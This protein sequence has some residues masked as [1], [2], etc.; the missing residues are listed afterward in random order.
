MDRLLHNFGS[1]VLL[2]TL[3]L[4]SQ[5]K[6]SLAYEPP[7]I[8]GSIKIGF[9]L[10]LS[11]DWAFLG[12]DVRDA[13][14]LAKQDLDN[15]SFHVELKFED[16]HGEL[17]ESAAAAYRLINLEKVDAI[18]SVISGVGLLIHPIAERAQVLNFGL[19]SNTNVAGGEFNF[20]NYI[21]TDEGA[22][23]FLQ[24]LTSGKQGRSRLGI[25]SL[26][27]EGFNQI[28]QQVKAQSA[29]KPVDILFVESF[30]PKTADFRPLILRAFRRT[31][32]TLLI[33]G[34]SPEIETL[35]HQLH[36]LNK[37]AELTSIEAF[38]LAQQKQVFD[39]SWYIDPAAPSDE[40]EERFRKNYGHEYTPPAPFAYDTVAII[41]KGFK[42]AWQGDVR[43]SRVSVA[44]T[45]HGIKEFQGIVGKLSVDS[46]G[47]FHSSPS[48]KEMTAGR[49]V[50]LRH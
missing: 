14:L 30:E 13:V 50:A 20:T 38:G 25:F 24:R 28:A 36:E 27:E 49:G 23:A 8:T 33:L 2:A 31:P 40:F 21:T 22:R 26:N 4:T 48:I 29:D 5:G 9:V 34:L 44:R 41:V 3:F 32:Q 10:P 47:I 17:K 6:I 35:A 43:P 39:G 1:F 16:N 12:N 42:E 19:C 45:I 7:Q 46:Q 18:V 11:G 37:D 15:S